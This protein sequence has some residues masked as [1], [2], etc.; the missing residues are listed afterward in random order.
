MITHDEATEQPK[1]ERTD[2]ESSPVHSTWILPPRQLTKVCTF[3][4]PLTAAAGPSAAPSSG[5]HHTARPRRSQ[6]PRDRSHL[7][8]FGLWR[9]PS[10]GAAPALCGPLADPPRRSPTRSSRLR[11]L[12]SD[13]GRGKRPWSTRAWIVLR[14]RPERA[15]TSTSR[16]GRMD[17]FA[18]GTPFVGRPSPCPSCSFS[19]G[20]ICT[21]AVSAERTR[22]PDFPLNSE[23]AHVGKLRPDLDPRRRDRHHDAISNLAALG[24]LGVAGAV[25]AN[26]QAAVEAGGAGGEP[27]LRVAGGD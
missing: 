25:D 9:M 12:S 15:I 27:G 10:P 20:A 7:R 11:A 13:T 19:T 8:V 18:A 26:G 6:S 22:P 2:R 23:V 24:H 21:E 4:W 16:S 3:R 5:Y 17:G 1:A 14:D